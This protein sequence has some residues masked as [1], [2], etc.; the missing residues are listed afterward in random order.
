M[1]YSVYCSNSRLEY[2]ADVR[3]HIFIIMGR[4]PQNGALIEK[5]ISFSSLFFFFF[6]F[7]FF[8]FFFGILLPC[9]KLPADVCITNIWYTKYIV[10]TLISLDCLRVYC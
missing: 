5:L 1:L 8:F 2:T 7:F 6:I 10:C 4:V 9:L 3:H